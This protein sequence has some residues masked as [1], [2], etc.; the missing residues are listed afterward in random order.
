[1]TNKKL[2]YKLTIAIAAMIVA[3]VV[4]MFRPIPYD[5]DDHLYTFIS[6]STIILGALATLVFSVIMLVSKRSVVWQRV[7]AVVYI[8]AS[9]AITIACVLLAV[10]SRMTWGSA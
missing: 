4:Y 8:L 5:W 3:I 1:M 7:C 9:I 6:M 10:V 2:F